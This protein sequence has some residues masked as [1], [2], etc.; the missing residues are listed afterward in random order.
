MGNRMSTKI[1]AEADSG[2]GVV[3][4]PSLVG[5]FGPLAL[6]GVASIGAGA[7]H[8]AAIGSHSE[9]RQ[10]VMVF[11]IL[12][13][14]QI[15]WGAVALAA[16]RRAVGLVGVAVH[17]AA[18]GGWLLAKRSGISF[19]NGLEA[20]EAI[21]WP[22]A[23]AVGLA[24]IA[25]FVSLRVVVAGASSGVPGRLV[26][27]GAGALVVVA[28]LA[29]M[30]TSS[31]HVHADGHAH[32]ESAATGSASAGGHHHGAAAA[33]ASKVYDPAGPVDLSGVAGVTSVQ[34]ARAESL[35]VMTLNRLPKYADTKVAEANG[36]RSIHDGLTGTEHFINWSYVNDDH[37][38]DPDYPESLVY[39]VGP[40]GTRKLVSAMF[41]MK[42]GTSLDD[43]PAVGGALTQWHIHDDLCLSDDPVAPSVAGITSIGGS[44]S[45][46]TVKLDP[47]P[48]LHVWITKNPCGPF[49]ALDGIGAGQVAAGETRSCDHVHGA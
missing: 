26:L 44:C 7:I 34:Q 36:F 48:M 40:T 4:R 14:V 22:D 30:T 32:G 35:V 25:L 9:H 47:M 6:A 1:G 23:L 29:G 18:V 42:E 2:A 39:E 20:V 33:V 43:V 5:A 19:V 11:T 13:L 3:P 46:P 28:S 37:L 38:L 15:G 49:A 41:M 12:A 27:S 17:A 10:A 45:P 21:Q 8:A 24:A 31:T 16:R